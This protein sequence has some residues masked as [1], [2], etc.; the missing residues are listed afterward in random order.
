[1]LG[2]C[3]LGQW[4]FVHDVAAH[5]LTISLPYEISQLSL[6][7]GMRMRFWTGSASL[8]L[9]RATAIVLGEDSIPAVSE[10]PSRATR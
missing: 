1:M 5:R 10:D 8:Q 9:G 7:E 2:D 6:Q 3:G 4:Q